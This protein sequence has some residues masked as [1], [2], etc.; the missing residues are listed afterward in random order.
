MKKE[1][2]YYFS[3]DANAKDDPKCVMLLEQLGCEGY[4]IFWILVETLR[5]QPNFKYPINL[6]PAIARRYNT[7]FEKVKAVVFSYGLFMVENDEFFYSESLIERMQYYL[8]RAQ[9][10]SMGGKKGME[11][12]WKNITENKGVITEPLRAHNTVITELLQTDNIDITN[13]NYKIKQNKIKQKNNIII[14]NS[15]LHVPYFEDSW[16][17]WIKYRKEIKKPLI[18]TTQT[19]QLKE[20]SDWLQAGHD[21]LAIIDQSIKRGWQGLFTL[22][23]G[24]NNGNNQKNGYKFD[25]EKHNKREAELEAM[26]RERD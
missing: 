19:K 10:K 23:I 9:L 25:P 24:Y 3:H 14:P 26:H 6:L 5:K 15:L 1:I 11:S 22:N 12:R 7:T 17:E 4:G 8:E 16:N 21:V 13:D 20:L 18:E 2:E